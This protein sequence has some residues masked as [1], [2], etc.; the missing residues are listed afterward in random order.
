VCI[1][2]CSCGLYASVL[3]AYERVPALSIVVYKRMHQSLFIGTSLLFIWCAA[4]RC[5][6]LSLRHMAGPNACWEKLRLDN[7]V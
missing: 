2:L 6:A 7:G 3:V 5:L 1:I 4:A